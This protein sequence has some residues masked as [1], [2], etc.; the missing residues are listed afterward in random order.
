[1][2]R[3]PSPEWSVARA[4]AEVVRCDVRTVLAAIRG[5]RSRPDQRL[6]DRIL[7]SLHALRDALAS[8]VRP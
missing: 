2:P 3:H 8:R 7:G 5:E 1:M 6:R 4:V